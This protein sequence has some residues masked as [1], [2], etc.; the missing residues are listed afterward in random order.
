MVLLAWLMP[1]ALSAQAP[2]EPAADGVVV[3]PS[4]GGAKKIR[5]QILSD[6][7]VHVTATP[8]GSFD[9]P[10][11]LMAIA[12]PS[13]KVAFDVGQDP[14]GSVFLKTS[15]LSVLISPVTGA[16]AFQDEDGKTLLASRDSGSF[17]PERLEGRDFFRLRQIF[18]EGTDEAFYGGGQHQNRQFNLNGQD[19]VLAQH[20]MDIA[21]PFFLSSRN[22]GVLWDNESITHFGAA[23]DYG[24][25]SAT[26]TV[27]D[28][29]GQ[30]GGLTALYFKDD[31][32]VLNRR[33]S[34]IDYQF[35]RDLARWPSEMGGSREM[36]ERRDTKHQRVV[37]EGS[38]ATSLAGLHKF[39]LYA[40]GYVTVTVDGQRLLERWRQNWNP[41]VHNFDLPMEAARP[42]AIRIEWTPDGGYIAL[43]HH[44]PL[45]EPERHALSL[46]SEVGNAIDYYFVAGR[47]QDEVISGY[48][49]ITG[50]A[51]LLPRWAYGFWQSRQRYKTAAELEAVVAAYRRRRLPLD[52]IVLDWFYW[53][54]ASWGSHDFDR[55]RFPD[56]AGMVT[57]LHQLH[58]KFYPTTANYQE[59]DGKGFIYRRNV[60]MA[61]RDWVGKGYLNAFYDPYAP[62]A[63]RIYWRQ[64]DEKLNILGIDGWWL[65]ASEPD[66][67]SNLDRD[68][69]LRRIGPTAL[70]P[71]AL[72]FNSY[73]LVHSGGVFDGLQQANPGSRSF[74]LTRSAF[75]GLQRYGAASW[76]GDVA[77]RWDD[78]KNQIPAALGYSLSG[79]PNWTSDIGGFAV[80]SRFSAPHPAPADQQEWRE[81]YLR[82]FQFGSLSPLFRA[83]G[84]FPY[85]EIYEV[86]PERSAIYRS[87]VWYDRLRYRL[88]PYI[89]SVA[90]DTYFRDGSILRALV[91]DF[92]QDARLRDTGD[93]YLFGSALLVSPVTDYGARRRTLVLP[94]GADWYDFASGE[95]LAGGQTINAAAPL[96]RM[97]LH[98]KAG[99]ILPIGP[100]A[101]YSDQKPG[102]PLTLL[103]FTGADGEFSLYEDDGVSTAYQRGAFSRIPLRYDQASG[104]LTIGARQGSFPGMAERRQFHVRFIS[105]QRPRPVSFEE[106]TDRKLLY[107]GREIRIRAE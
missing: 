102:A 59:L 64:I 15:F 42:R 19:L 105:G 7:I 83:H 94:A 104:T 13:G 65:D 95:R 85:R 11:S 23:E 73:P 31:R 76:S 54:E 71:A 75:A 3:S 93:Q 101:Q 97:P 33:E 21:I 5:L 25:L 89:Y 81:L 46:T 69:L 30:P 10:A 79:I 9:L 107:D 66:V 34:E 74:I 100:D 6:R 20:N 18:N 24:P 86:A 60:E 82:W 38:L 35:I 26:L 45:P 87:L 68:E 67:H 78:L 39:Q 48:R 44:D 41:W 8:T 70:G 28:K 50:K 61:E 77:A 103:V 17:T 57:W 88:L 49:Q 1:F 40:S 91:S 96:E 2:F 47:S 58:A 43:H 29:D 16:I 27:T 80:E 106:G 55:D 53:P 12:R 62:E 72:T 98:V 32:L 84:E 51:V 90:A 92:P 63:R 36:A 99:S 4:Q 52:N 37:W 22:Y 14:T 56:P